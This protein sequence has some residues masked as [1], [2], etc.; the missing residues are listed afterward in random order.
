MESH[1]CKSESE[2][3][4]GNLRAQLQRFQQLNEFC[5][6]AVADIRALRFRANPEQQ[7]KRRT[8]QDGPL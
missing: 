6:Q 2:T 8:T 5:D 7:L 3:I 4:A 1:D